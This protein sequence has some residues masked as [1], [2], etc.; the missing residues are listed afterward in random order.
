MFE[1]DQQP[2]PGQSAVEARGIVEQRSLPLI[3]IY[4]LQFLPLS[5]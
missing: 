5:G 3:D 1:A 2:T 4:G